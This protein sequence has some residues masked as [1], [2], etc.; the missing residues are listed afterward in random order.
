M[1]WRLKNNNPSPPPVGL[2]FK[3]LKQAGVTCHLDAL[4]TPVGSQ[5]GLDR[6]VLFLFSPTGGG[7][8]LV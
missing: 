3:S 7:K 5:P 8:G 6:N 1:A 4:V 2:A